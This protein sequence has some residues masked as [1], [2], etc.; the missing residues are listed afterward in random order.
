M[1]RAVNVKI[2]QVPA[3]D[4]RSAM[5]GDRPATPIHPERQTTS[6][7]AADF[8]VLMFIID[9][10]LKVQTRPQFFGWCQGLLQSLVPHELL[11]CALRDAQTGAYVFDSF[12]SRQFPADCLEELCRRE[13]GTVCHAI[14]LWQ[15]QHRIPLRYQSGQTR[16]LADARLESDIAR[17]SLENLVAHGS[18]LASAETGSFFA[19][20][21]LPEPVGGRHAYLLD[22]L[23]PFMHA[24]WIRILLNRPQEKALDCGVQQALLTMR[25]LEILGWVYEGK[26]NIEIGA[27]LQ[28]SSLTV[29]N[30]VQKILR[31]LD[32]QNRTQAVSKGIALNL[33]KR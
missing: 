11:I 18:S 31:K 22:L 13:V 29:K 24:A 32:V 7:S 3:V 10:S 4:E 2:A 16:V 14:R 17:F 33:L 28:I 8:E 1:E 20:A 30:H 5:G 9:A 12:Y 26:S 27:I 19:F 23:V 25:E 15:R 21:C 6:L